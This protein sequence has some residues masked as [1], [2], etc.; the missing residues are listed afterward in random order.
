ML[1]T[2]VISRPGN[3]RLTL[4]LGHKAVAGD[5]P[6]GKRVIFPAL[7]EAKA[8]IH[9]EEHIVLETPEAERFQPGDAL[10][11]IPVHICPTCALH[12]EVYAV[13][14]DRVVGVWQV[15]S[16]DRV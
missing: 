12:K 6:A 3:G 7:P 4:D 11:A 16:R 8:V 10:L 1:L 13:E 9:S 15:A 14:G 2:R 5:P